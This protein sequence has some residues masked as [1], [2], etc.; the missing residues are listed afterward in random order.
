MVKTSC[1]I[2]LLAPE[3]SLKSKP[4]QN[5]M[6]EIM[7][8]NVA[9]ALKNSNIQYSSIRLKA[10]RIFFNTINPKKAIEILKICF[11]IN[12]LIDSYNLI[13][14]KEKSKDESLE[15]VINYCLSACEK[16]VSGEFAVRAKSFNKYVG[17]RQ[18][19]LRLGSKILENI[20]G[21]KVKLSNP[22]CQCNVIV[23][24]SEVFV[25]FNS[26]DG[27]KGM[28]L[29]VQGKVAIN[30][31]NLKQGG[32]LII[33]LMKFGCLPVLIKNNLT[34]KIDLKKYNSYTDLEIV[35]LD[36]AKLSF[37]KN[38]TKAF[39]CDTT[40]LDEKKKFDRL[41]ETKSFAPFLE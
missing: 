22:S 17:A 25:Y 36:E 39:F 10:G 40:S 26:V 14:D 20:K 19:E 8:N 27:A 35:S 28:P 11:G 12:L 4:V 2:A 23:F 6:H 41:I 29:G 13:F 18:I 37:V 16:N 31:T 30:I 9:L 33:N 24:E 21:T 32:E 1:V 5:R 3:I 38:N 15:K 7:K 34:S